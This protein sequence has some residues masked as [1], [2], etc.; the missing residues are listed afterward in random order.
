MFYHGNAIV[1]R[2]NQ[3]TQVTAYTFFLVDF[4][5]IVWCASFD[6]DGLVRCVFTRNKTQSAMDAFVLI[7]VGD[8]MVIDV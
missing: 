1:N 7:D 2:A 4:V 5:I 3:F 8:M 6:I